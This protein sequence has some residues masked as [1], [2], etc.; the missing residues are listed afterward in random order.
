MRLHPLGCGGNLGDGSTGSFSIYYIY[1]RNY[2]EKAIGILTNY[3]TPGAQEGNNYLRT[4]WIN[5][6]NAQAYA[7]GY[8]AGGATTDDLTASVWFYAN[9]ELTNDGRLFLYDDQDAYLSFIRMGEQGVASGVAGQIAW[10]DNG[11]WKNSSIDGVYAANAWHHLEVAT[12]F[13]NSKYTI[14]LNDELLGT[15]AINSAAALN[16][17]RINLNGWSSGATPAMFDDVTVAS[18]PEPM[19]LVLMVLGLTSLAVVNR[20]RRR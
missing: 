9:T 18:V 6:T 4:G 20:R 5:Q 14:T 8:L 1:R 13:A 2:D 15:S 11:T 19:S 12:D 16:L 7:N 10:I 3:G 17:N